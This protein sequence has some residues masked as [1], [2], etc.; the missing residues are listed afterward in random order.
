MHTFVKNR[1]STGFTIVELLIIIA[2]IAILAAITTISYNSVTKSAREASVSTDLKSTASNLAKYKTENG[3]FPSNSTV[4]NSTIEKANT[5]SK[6]TYAYTYEPIAGTYCLVATGHGSSYNLTSSNSIVKD[7]SACTF[8]SSLAITTP[9]LDAVPNDSLTITGK[10]TPGNHIKAAICGTELNGYA[11]G[12]R[13]H[14][15]TIVS[16]TVPASG[17]WTLQVTMVEA[18]N[19]GQSI[20]G[21]TAQA[22]N[23]LCTGSGQCAVQVI[24]FGTN[25]TPSN[26]NQAI[27]SKS[28]TVYAQI[29]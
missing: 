20:I 23:A 9:N 11:V 17:N 21:G 29:Q 16:T 4:F 18:V 1:R 28:I 27:G 12:T 3:S 10:A 26:L 7:G 15:S 22:T 6:T 19:S 14:A 25:A 24:D 2:V 8:P 5:S 13:C